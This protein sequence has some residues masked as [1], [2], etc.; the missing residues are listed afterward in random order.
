[1]RTKLLVPSLAVLMLG[2]AA[3]G[4]GSSSSGTSSASRST[5]KR[6][7]PRR[8]YRVALT[9]A[10][11]K[12]RGAPAGSGAAVIAFHGSSVVCWRFAHLHG[13]TNAT[14]ADIHLGA[15]GRLGKLIVPLSTGPRLHHQ[16]CV[17]VATSLTKAIEHSPHKYY[18][19]IHST[20]YP[21]GAVRGQL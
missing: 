5:A 18:V 15:A 11:E 14:F 20:Q 21:G 12:P 6:T 8:I 9:G 17:H 16:G 19:N 2:L 13:F 7:G 1:M 3:C 10:G 4:S